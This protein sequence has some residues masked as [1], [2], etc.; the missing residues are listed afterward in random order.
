MEAAP[1]A[2]YG[3]IPIDPTSVVVV[4]VASDV[5]YMEWQHRKKKKGILYD[6]IK[7]QHHS[8]H[9]SS[10]FSGVALMSPHTV[11]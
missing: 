5:H 1:L 8:P 2:A 4:A 6:P 3:S 9:L 10:T 7:S 11:S